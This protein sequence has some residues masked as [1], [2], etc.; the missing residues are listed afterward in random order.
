MEVGH[1]P[2]QRRRVPCDE[3][4]ATS[5]GSSLAPIASVPADKAEL[6]SHALSRA[7]ILLRSAY[8]PGESL[9]A[10]RRD[11]AHVACVTIC[12]RRCDF[13]L[14]ERFAGFVLDKKCDPASFLDMARP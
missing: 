5:R 6:I 4:I 8:F 11:A 10:S 12:D 3:C 1:A 2:T 13:T 9:A 14:A 7:M